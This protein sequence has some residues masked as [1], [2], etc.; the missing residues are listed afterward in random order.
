MLYALGEIL[1]VFIGILLALQVNTWWEDYKARQYEKKILLEIQ[2]SLQE[3]IED[4]T[5]LMERGRRT[6]DGALRITHHL[7]GQPLS[8]DSLYMLVD[9]LRLRRVFQYNSGP[10]ESLKSAGLERISNDSLR[11]ALIALYEDDLPITDKLIN[12]VLR[13]RISDNEDRY[14]EL[15]SLVG[16]KVSQ[17]GGLIPKTSMDPGLVSSELFLSFVH[18]AFVNGR[19]LENAMASLEDKMQN[20]KGLIS[21]ELKRP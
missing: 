1:L 12:E 8:S 4:V 18:E 16:L 5:S 6:S 21:R 2:I 20:L 13:E 11:I 10:Y 7:T 15:F 14:R 17:G 3:G 9:D 19:L